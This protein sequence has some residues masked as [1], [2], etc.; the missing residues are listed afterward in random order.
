M[1]GVKGTTLMDCKVA[2]VMFTGTAGLLTVPSDAVM[3]AVPPSTP[4]ATPETGLIAAMEELEDNQETA[5]VMSCVVPSLNVP[6][7]VNCSV[8][9]LA[10]EKLAGVT[11]MEA[12]VAEVTVRFA[13][14]L[15]MPTLP[16][17]PPARRN[18][19]PFAWANWETE[20]GP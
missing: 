13:A 12:S 16:G 9:P 7:A 10:M 6:M 4:T 18:G 15:A 2:L 3:F 11:E 1:E 5:C 8:A 14:G 20:F 19:E 17:A